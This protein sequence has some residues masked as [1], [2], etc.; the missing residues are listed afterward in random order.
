MAHNKKNIVSSYCN[1]DGQIVQRSS[2]R[3]EYLDIWLRS[4]ATDRCQF[5][6]LDFVKNSKI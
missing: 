1:A 6:I 2:L 3:G 4:I 5:R